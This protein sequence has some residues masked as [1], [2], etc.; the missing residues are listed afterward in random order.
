[1]GRLRT[2][3]LVL[4]CWASLAL[5][6]GPAQAQSPPDPATPPS[7]PSAPHKVAAV[8]GNPAATTYANGTG[9]LGR[10]LGLRDEWGIRLGGVWLADTNAV[11]AGGAKPDGWT[12]NSALFIGLQIDAEKL[13]GWRGGSFGFEFLQFNG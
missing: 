7:T 2:A 8:S 3:R 9:W 5:F 13:V 4:L 6:P 12:N 1:M 10:T 11:A